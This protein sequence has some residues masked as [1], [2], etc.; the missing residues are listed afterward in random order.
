MWR[1]IAP[2]FIEN[3]K[4][5]NKVVDDVAFNFP[6]LDLRPCHLQCTSSKIVIEKPYY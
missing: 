2:T 4:L 3:T 5:I 6:Y 1:S